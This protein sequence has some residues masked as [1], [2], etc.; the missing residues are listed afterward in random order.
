MSVEFLKTVREI[1][2]ECEQKIKKAEAAKQTALMEAEK[3][4]VLEA[5][6]SEIQAKEEAN[7]ILSG[8]KERVDKEYVAMLNVFEEEQNNLKEKAKKIEKK[9]IDFILSVIV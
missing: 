2:R 5:R 1:E 8:V 7:I 3:K 9:A 4:G 6:D